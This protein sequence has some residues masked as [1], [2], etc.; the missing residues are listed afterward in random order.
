MVVVRSARLRLLSSMSSSPLSSS[1]WFIVL[2]STLYLS[3]HKLFIVCTKGW[4]VEGGA[5]CAR[6]GVHEV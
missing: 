1:D 2:A 5:G 4:V 3:S 6:G